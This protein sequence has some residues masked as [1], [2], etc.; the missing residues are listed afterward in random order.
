MYNKNADHGRGAYLYR[1]LHARGLHK[2]YRIFNGGVSM[3][4]IREI[5]PFQAYEIR[6]R[7]AGWN[8]KWIV[9]VQVRCPAK[10]S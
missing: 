1:L 2:R 3:V 6:T 5:K 7:I 4:F 9:L 10:L 8:K